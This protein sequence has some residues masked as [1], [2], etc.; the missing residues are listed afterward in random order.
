[1]PPKFGN[2]CTPKGVFGPDLGILVAGD[3]AKAGFSLAVNL[4]LS[5]KLPFQLPLTKY[6]TQNEI[7]TSIPK[8]PTPPQ[9]METPRRLC[10]PPPPPPEP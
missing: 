2:S 10:L 9:T 4:E 8:Y 1:M 7:Q 3:W 6:G 5:Q